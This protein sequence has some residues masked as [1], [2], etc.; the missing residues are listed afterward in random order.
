MSRA[1]VEVERLRKVF[2][3]RN[4]DPNSNS[5]DM[6]FAYLLGLLGR[7]A[8][9]FSADRRVKVALDDVSLGIAEGEFFGVL[10]P[11]GA[12]KTTLVKVLATILRPTSGRARVAGHDV[13]RDAARVRAS[14]TVVPAS[15]WL[16]FD[17]QLTVAQNLAF[18][19]SL[20]GLDRRTARARIR[21]VLAVVG[22]DE[23]HD[24]T[25]SHL[26]SGMRQRLAVAK[27]LLFRAPLFVLD[28][29]TANVDPAG[30][31]Q[32][33]DFIRNELNRALGQTVMLTTHDMAEAEQLCDR[34]AI[35]DGGRIIAQG[36]PSELAARLTSRVVEVSLARR[37]KQ[38]VQVLRE[39]RLALHVVDFLD[40]EGGGRLRVHLLPGIGGDAVRTSLAAAG[41]S[42]DG[43][44]A[45]PANLQDVFLSSTGRGLDGG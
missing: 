16:A 39:R 1:I 45:A 21:D 29:P 40:G 8:G 13:E 3:Y 4:P 25:P 42:V 38:A 18:W 33:R 30:A 19:G 27:G 41:L 34:V 14:L 44:R 36:R 10:G 7:A 32:I 2:S 12:G 17:S 15:G 35:V 6:W 5:P 28:E 37:G 22:L 20:Y 24:A 31:Y 23:W 11:N 43:V 26:S 9:E